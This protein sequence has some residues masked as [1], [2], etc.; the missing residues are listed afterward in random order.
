MSSTEYAHPPSFDVVYETLFP[1][2]YRVSLRVTGDREIAE[3]LCHE[4]FIKL[5]QRSDLLPDLEQSK[6]WL[7]RVVKNLSLNY[8]KRKT[9]EKAAYTRLTRLSRGVADSSE[10]QIMREETRSNVQSALDALPFN[11]RAPLVFREYGDLS[12]KEIGAILGIS[13]SNVKVRIFRARERL[14]KTLGEGDAYV[15]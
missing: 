11:L 2:I 13:E 10:K 4:A 3:D 6:Y 8:E 9:R 15:S 14:E 7:I 5:M 1:I 12:Y